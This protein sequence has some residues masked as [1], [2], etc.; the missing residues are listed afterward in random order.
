MS[1]IEEADK[2]IEMLNR[3]VSAFLNCRFLIH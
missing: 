3:Y 2:A 1:T